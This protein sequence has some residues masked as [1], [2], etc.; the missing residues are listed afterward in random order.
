MC[1]VA[2]GR[3]E[4]KTTGFWPAPIGRMN[5][6][7]VPKALPRLLWLRPFSLTVSAQLAAALAARLPSTISNLHLRRYDQLY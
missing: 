3:R 7:F 6:G 4:R 2:G 1:P 5:Q